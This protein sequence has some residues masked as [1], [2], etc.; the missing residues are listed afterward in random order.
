V[1]FLDAAGQADL[2]AVHRRGAVSLA[3]DCLSRT[4][5]AEMTQAARPDRGCLKHEGERRP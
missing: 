1:T 5:V 2:P 4:V 3:A